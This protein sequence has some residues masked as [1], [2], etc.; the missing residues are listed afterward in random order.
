MSLVTPVLD[1]IDEGKVSVL[2]YLKR[3][4]SLLG[5]EKATLFLTSTNWG[6]LAEEII[7]SPLHQEELTLKQVRGL[8]NPR[9]FTKLIIRNLTVVNSGSEDQAACNQANIAYAEQSRFEFKRNDLRVG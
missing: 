8:R 6:R 7:A 3:V 4:D 2:D 1:L 5:A 9:V